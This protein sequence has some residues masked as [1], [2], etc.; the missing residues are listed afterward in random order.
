MTT[1]DLS[2]S[3]DGGATFPN[4]IATGEAN[5]GTYAWTVPSTATT[6]A[7]VK[8][9]AHDAAANSGEDQS[10]A[11]FTIRLPDTTPPTVTVTAPNGG[12]SIQEGGSTDIT[13][14]A[15]DTG[16]KPGGVTG[17]A[18]A[19]AGIDSVTISY[20]LNN[21]STWTVI[22]TGEA[23]DGTYAWTL[24]MAPS[25]SALVRVAAYDTTGNSG[26][27]VSDAVF[28]ITSSTGIGEQI[29]P[30]ALTLSPARPNPLTGAGTAISFGLTREGSV[31]LNVFDATGRRVAALA[32]GSYPEGFHTV[33][34]DGRRQ[35]GSRAPAGIYFYRLVTPEGSRSQRLMVLR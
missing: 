1:V 18:A 6:A 11:D 26:S 19:I 28:R 29:M 10:D 4:V 27:D 17:L 20:S 22:A 8:V 23:N 32:G 30:V 24:P 33:V 13:W 7:R 3:I 14:T 15:N 35:D 34:W 5:D 16:L 12:E 21:G 2:Y 25:D 31:S 9:V